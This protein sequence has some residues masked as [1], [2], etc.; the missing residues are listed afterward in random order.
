[1]TI[2]RIANNWEI[3]Y[4]IIEL[5]DSWLDQIINT[6]QEKKQDQILSFVGLSF[7]AFISIKKKIFKNIKKLQEKS[8][9]LHYSLWK[10]FSHIE[11]NPANFKQFIKNWLKLL[12]KE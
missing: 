11:M 8:V 12:D 4:G 3:W 7:R 10:T 2:S 1:M 5:F 9:D 6:Y